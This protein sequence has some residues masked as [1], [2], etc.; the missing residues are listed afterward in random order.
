METLFGRERSER[1]TRR[2]HL[3]LRTRARRRRWA[4]G[5]RFSQY[6]LLACLCTDYAGMVG[7]I[8]KCW[9]PSSH[10]VWKVWVVLSEKVVKRG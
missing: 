3:L 7:N 2:N 4:L 5:E 10:S 1:M 6:N 8:T 9:M